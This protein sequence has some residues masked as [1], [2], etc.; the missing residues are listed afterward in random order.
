MKLILEFVKIFLKLTKPKLV[1][2]AIPKGKFRTC[3]VSYTLQAPTGVQ[4]DISR[5]DETSVEPAMLIQSGSPLAF[6]QS[7]GI[8]LVYASGG[9]TQ[10]QTSNVAA[11]FAGVLVRQAPGIA[12]SIASDAS[13]SPSVPN[14]VQVQGMAVRGYVNV[15]CQYGTPVRGGIVYIRT[16]ATSGSRLLGGFEAT[17]DPGNNVALSLTQASWATDGFDASLNAE[18]RI[19]R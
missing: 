17:S 12:G 2:I 18:L 5:A 15:I 16:A 19:A 6:A 7:F 8:P 1:R 4:G 9:V 10:Y 14:P 3:D 13:F 11:D